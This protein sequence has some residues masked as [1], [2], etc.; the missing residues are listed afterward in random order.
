AT[1]RSISGGSRTLTVR[2]SIPSDGATDWDD[3]ELADPRGDG[4]IPKNRRPRYA[5]HDL[6]EQLQPFPAQAVLELQKAGSVAAWPC[7][8]L[9]ETGANRS[10]TNANTIGTV[11][12]ACSNGPTEAPPV[13]K[14][15]SGASATNSAAYLRAS[16]ALP[17]VQRVSIRT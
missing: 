4:G 12:V 17:A 15:T 1:A 3:R 7:Q 11:R 8:A 5:R 2:T 14:M 9:D 13:V 6:L 10:G 16:S